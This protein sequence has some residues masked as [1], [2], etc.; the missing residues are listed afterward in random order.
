MWACDGVMRDAEELMDDQCHW[1]LMRY[2]DFEY[3]SSMSDSG[4]TQSCLPVED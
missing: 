3:L 2:L 1:D 4:A